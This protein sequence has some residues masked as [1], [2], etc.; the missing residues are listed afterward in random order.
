MSRSSGRE[1]LT[2]RVAAIAAEASAEAGGVPVGLLG[3]YL[4]TLVAVAA[5][6]RR[7][8][9][10]ELDACRG[11]GAEAGRLNT[12]PAQLVDLY[13]SATRLLWEQLPRLVPAQTGMRVPAGEL[14]AMG[15]VVLRAAD[16]ALAAV[17]AGYADARRGA[18]RQEE[19]YRRE[20]IDDLLGGQADVGGLVE[21]AAGYGLHLPARHLVAVIA[22][23]PPFSDTGVVTGGAEQALRA[24]F[25]DREVLVASKDG[26][27]VCVVPEALGGGGGD[28]RLLLSEVAAQVAGS[29]RGRCQAAVGRA[30]PGAR[31][32]FR[33]YLEARETLELAGRLGLT[34]AVVHPE[35][36]LVYRVL[37]RDQAAM[38][39]LVAAVLAPLEQARGGA[40][41]LLATLAAYFTAGNA[42]ETA[43]RM[44]LSVRA[45]TYRLNRV[46]ELTGYTPS[47]P[48]QRL[49]LEVAV[50]GARLLGWPDQP[51]PGRQ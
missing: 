46:R 29:A 7:L 34:D 22:A 35:Q 11:S 20:F 3:E 49:P 23:D 18:V 30:Q 16:Q 4:P 45:V 17:A 38:T 39:D 32:V 28:T 36:V 21:R 37:V 51:L 40:A 26:R 41:P 9:R 6:G 13:L 42:V 48:A 44:H 8:N 2:R 25:A 31:G 14:L 47:D 27:L 43:R 12:A 1:D 50:V 33:S 24:R 15:T 5:T 19:A 10:A